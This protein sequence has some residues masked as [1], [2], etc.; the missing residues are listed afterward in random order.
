M[1]IRIIN[2]EIKNRNICANIKFGQKRKGWI[3]VKF[4]ELNI[5]SASGCQFCLFYR[6]CNRFNDPICAAII[7][8][9]TASGIFIITPPHF[10]LCHEIKS[11]I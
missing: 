5:N 9:I 7:S 1:K 2:S 4:K 10:C 11:Q 3:K 8:E 6:S